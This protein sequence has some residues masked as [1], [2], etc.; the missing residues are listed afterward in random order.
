MARCDLLVTGAG[1]FVGRHVVARGLEQGLNVE[2]AACDLRSGAAVA[3]LVAVAS[4]A[5]VVHLAASPRPPGVDPWHTLAE[6]LVMAGAV[7]SAV[8]EH[9]PEAP[10]LFAGSAAQ[11]GMG[12]ADPL[13]ESDPLAPLS[14]YG[15]AKCVL[16]RA[17]TQAAL[18]GGVRVIWA[19]SFNH[20]G[21]GQGPD[22]PVAQW[23]RQVAA[24]ELAG[25]GTLRTGALDVVRDFLDVRDVADAYLA[26]VRSPA[27]GAVNVCSGEPTPLS[28]LVDVIV[29]LATVAIELERDPAQER[30]VDPPVVVGDPGRLRALTGWA[31]RVEL[32]A[33]VGELLD[34]CRAARAAATPKAGRSS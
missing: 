4:P 30:R 8:A 15:A 6:D 16:E 9:A 33:S 21:P 2:S 20:V 34:E 31:P 18:N 22:A 1:G 3:E 26:L 14:P 25:G 5:A 11:Y 32:A 12:L 19:R 29:D 13:R 7:L 23:A 24:A 28:L 17:C 10:V 27:E